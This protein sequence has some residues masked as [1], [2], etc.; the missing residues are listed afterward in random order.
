MARDPGLCEVQPTDLIFIDTETTGLVGGAGTVAFL[1]GLGTYQS[2]SFRIRQFFLRNPGEE[3]SMLRMLRFAV[4]GYAIPNWIAR[5][6]ST[7]S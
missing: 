4:V 7:Q 2:G 6:A 3:Q 5:E 1:I